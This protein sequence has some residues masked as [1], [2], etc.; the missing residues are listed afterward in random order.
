MT[1]STEGLDPEVA[2][3]VAEIQRT[4]Q[5][6]YPRA[7]FKTRP[8]P[9]GRVFLDVFTEAENDFDIH[10]LVAERTVDFLIQSKRSVHIFPRGNGV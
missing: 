2:A 6:S 4:I 1:P 8:A 9:D 7:T 5:T 10:D 3:I